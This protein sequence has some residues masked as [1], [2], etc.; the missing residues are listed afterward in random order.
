MS[1]KIEELQKKIERGE[2]EQIKTQINRPNISSNV[3][4]N[5]SMINRESKALKYKK[6][7]KML[8]NHNRTSSCVK[9]IS[10]K[11]DNIKRN[12]SGLIN[13]NSWLGEKTKEKKTFKSKNTKRDKIRNVGNSRR[14]EKVPIPRNTLKLEELRDCLTNYFNNSNPSSKNASN[15]KSLSKSILLPEG[16]SKKK[17]KVQRATH[18]GYGKRNKS[19]L[20]F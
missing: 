9:L 12:Y 10:G 13:H 17:N 19:Q 5:H 11:N 8:K 20:H 18:N 4:R 6:R 15:Y 14:E 1:R 16:K 2:S 3:S 7:E